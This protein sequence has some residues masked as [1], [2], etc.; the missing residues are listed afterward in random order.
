MSVLREFSGRPVKVIIVGEESV[1][2][3]CSCENG[4]SKMGMTGR[5]FGEKD[6]E[7]R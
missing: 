4:P 2:V 5:R 7:M 6:S 1:W 3:T